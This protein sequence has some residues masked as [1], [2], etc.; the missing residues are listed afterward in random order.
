MSME[1]PKAKKA[2]KAAAKQNVKQ[3]EDTEDEEDE[4]E[5]KPTVVAAEKNDDGEAFFELSKMR[6][7]TVREFKGQVLIDIREVCVSLKCLYVVY[8]LTFALRA[9]FASSLTQTFVA[10]FFSTQTKQ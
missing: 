4:D 7:L 10:S 6:R 3:E 8:I 9:P 1:E 5:E 2:R